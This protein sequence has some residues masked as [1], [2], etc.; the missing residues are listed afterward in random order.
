MGAACSVELAAV[1]CTSG[2]VCFR[3]HDCALRHARIQMGRQRHVILNVYRCDECH[4]W[5]M[6]SSPQ[7]KDFQTLRY[8]KMRSEESMP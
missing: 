4:G 8:I 7:L 3:T 1:T 2:K 6:T 5:H